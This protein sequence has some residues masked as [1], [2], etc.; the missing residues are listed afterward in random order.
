MKDTVFQHI[1]KPITKKLLTECIMKYQS[2]RDY[3]L[4]KTREHLQTMIYANINQIKSLRTLEV[5]INSQQLSIKS[6][7][8]RSTLSDANKKRSSECFLWI[9]TQLMAW[10]P[11]R[12]CRQIQKVVKILDSTPISLKGFGYDAWTK[13]LATSR[14]QGLNLHVEYDLASSIP[15]KTAI[16]FPRVNDLSV[17]REWKT[18]EETIYVFD[19][20][21]CDY[22]WWWR[23]N[24]KKAYFVTRLKKDAAIVMETNTKLL[25]ESILEDGTFHFKNKNPRGGS[26]NEYSDN[27][28]RVC[29]KREGKKP[30]ILVTNLKDIAAEQIADLYR[31][32]WRIELF[33]KWIKQN[34]KIKKFLGKSA[35]AVKIQ[36]I[37]A[38][39]TYLLIY[40]YKLSI[41]DIRSL[42]LIIVWLQ[43]NLHKRIKWLKK[44][45]PP[46][47]WQNQRADN[48]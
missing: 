35:N 28:R 8:K 26:K 34:L 2:D 39:I 32:R 15:T 47:Y 10:L 23:I 31:Y 42:Q 33:F 41:K 13:A 29:V 38:L 7:V 17:G 19:K 40:I 36:I 21:Y 9:L 3:E 25:S 43:H 4:F 18:K 6:K 48:L 27:L 24:Q 37:T 46:I 1:F 44:Q 45:S 14:C 20:A 22:N 30:L 12:R 5:A 11:Q 16:H